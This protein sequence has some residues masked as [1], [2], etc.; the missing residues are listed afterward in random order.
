MTLKEKIA[1]LTQ[2][3]FDFTNFDEVKAMVEEYQV[4]SLILGGSAFVGDGDEAVVEKQKLADIS[5]PFTLGKEEV[6]ID[7]GDHYTGYL[8]IAARGT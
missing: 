2:I 6:I 8:H 7:F 4:G 3:S 5:F 1:Q